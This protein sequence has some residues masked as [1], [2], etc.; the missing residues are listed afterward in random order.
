MDMATGIGTSAVGVTTQSQ[1]ITLNGNPSSSK[2]MISSSTAVRSGSTQYPCFATHIFVATIFFLPDLMALSCSS[3]C[4]P[5]RLVHRSAGSSAGSACC[6]N[7][8]NRPVSA[9]AAALS[10]VPSF[11]KDI[12]A[13][14]PS[15]SKLQFL[16]CSLRAP[17]A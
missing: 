14:T 13:R 2:T 7:G 9:K 10:R 3:G 4:H 16:F 15:R 11:A 12:Q 17:A 8:L 5:T 6:L 1:H